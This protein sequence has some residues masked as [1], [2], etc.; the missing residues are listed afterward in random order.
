MVTS[1][2]GTRRVIRPRAEADTELA[3]EVKAL[4]ACGDNAAACVRFGEVVDQH[5]RRAARIAYHYLRDPGEVDDAVQDAFLK[6]FVHLPSFR[7]ELFFELWFTRILV[8]CCL[9]RLKVRNRRGRWLVP[10]S[11]DDRVRA[12]RQPAVEPSPE[13]A[14]LRRERRAG[15]EA[16]IDRLPARQRSVVILSHLEGHS[17]REVAGMLDL[18]EATVRVHLFRAVRSLR[19]LLRGERWLVG[20]RGARVSRSSGGR[21]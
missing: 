20:G 18:K 15:L 2:P 17:T 7:E 12:E 3:A 8:N 10:T 1:V 5:Q 19:R 16:A 9:D 4:L 21:G 14:L 6:A 11:D 13:T